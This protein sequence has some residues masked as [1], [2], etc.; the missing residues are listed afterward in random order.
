MSKD[1]SEWKKVFFLTCVRLCHEGSRNVV[2]LSDYVVVDD[3]GA[4]SGVRCTARRV[5]LSALCGLAG[6]IRCT[7]VPQSVD[8]LSV[9]HHKR[10]VSTSDL[11]RVGGGAVGAY[12]LADSDGLL[13]AGLP[14]AS[15]AL[16]H[17]LVLGALCQLVSGVFMEF[18]HIVSSVLVVVGDRVCR[19]CIK[20]LFAGLLH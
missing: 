16:Q 7:A 8:G 19:V 17:H 15:I 6:S 13:A 20:D 4:V 12:R 14:S 2:E 3:G 18:P 11:V 5:Q 1:F 9:G 10:L